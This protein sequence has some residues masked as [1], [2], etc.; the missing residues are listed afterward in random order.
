MFDLVY[1][2]KK[3]DDRLALTRVYLGIHVAVLTSESSRDVDLIGLR[4]ELRT[5]DSTL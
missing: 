1:R 3:Y 5:F 4:L 2:Y